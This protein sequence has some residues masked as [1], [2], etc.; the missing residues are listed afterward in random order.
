[1]RITTIDNKNELIT[2]DKYKNNEITGA[3]EILQA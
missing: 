1:M 2:I 3:I